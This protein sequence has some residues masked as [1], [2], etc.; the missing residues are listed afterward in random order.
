MLTL[1]TELQNLAALQATQDRI[2]EAL[3]AL[4]EL[5]AEVQEHSATQAELLKKRNDVQD[6][7]DTAQRAWQDLESGVA[8]RKEELRQWE[9][10]MNGLSDWREQQALQAAIRDQKRQIEYG[11]R[12]IREKV[13]QV[14]ALEDEYN[15]A[16]EALEDVE[17]KVA[18]GEAAYAGQRQEIEDNL[19]A[20]YQTRDEL[21]AA[22]P[23][24]E[25]RRWENFSR[26]SQSKVVVTAHDGV[27]GHCHVSLLPM[28]WI[29]VLKKEK[30]V[31]CTGCQRIIVHESFLQTETDAVPVAEAS[32]ASA[33]QEADQPQA[34]AG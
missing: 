16:Q 10:R 6:R 4:D 18:D 34:E 21:L 25:R 17:R 8:S 11:E 3:S 28:D 27:C 33:E 13:E 15:G 29:E 5:K 1:S 19:A 30:P 32:D 9:N 14:T 20:E 7:F 2:D 23:A 22:C 31:S 12:D 26:R 24:S